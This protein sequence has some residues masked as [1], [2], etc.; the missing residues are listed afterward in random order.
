M[1]LRTSPL[2]LGIV[3]LGVAVMAVSPLISP[4][5]PTLFALVLAKGIVVLGII[6]LLQAG[7]VSFGHA[8]FFGVGAYAVAFWGKYLGPSDMA[9]Y[10]VLGTLAGALSGVVVGLFVVRYRQ[11]F[12]GML[13]LA[14]SMV[15]WS[16]LEKMFHITNGA[17]GIRV[18]RP[19]M[20]GMVLTPDGFSTAI[21]YLTLGL[22]LV[23]TLLVQRYL[24]SPLGHMLRAIKSNETRLEYLGVSARRVLLIGYVISAALGGLGG[25]LVAVVQQI[26]T[27]E[28]AYWTKSGEFVFIA[29]LG[30]AG[31][32]LGAFAG[33]LVFEFVRFYAS[34]Q[35][36]DAWQL[37]LGVVLIA[38]ILFAPSG[39]IG[40]IRAR[41]AVAKGRI[42]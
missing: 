9:L 42:V 6:I 16:L 19:T 39:L 11:I 36:A 8:M 2:T 32:A 41:G 37:I 3:G 24:A 14:F 26:A 23:A 20:F 10:L 18:P 40:L 30:G 25:S 31:N 35:V 12:F 28:F 4:S 34:A 27:P 7:Q 15:L 22:A 5:L 33:S 38:I 29:I 1:H 21:L 13:N 17:D